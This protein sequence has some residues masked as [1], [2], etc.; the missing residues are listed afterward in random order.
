MRYP[1]N[2]NYWK[3]GEWQAVNERLHDMEKAGVR[4]NPDRSNLFRSLTATGGVE[5]TRVVIVGQDPYPGHTM[6]TG[7]AFSIPRV[8]DRDRFPPTLRQFFAEYSRDLGYGTPSH[9]DLSEWAE[10]GVLLW[11]AIPSCTD[12]RSLSHDWP[13]YE[14]LNREIFGLLSQK[15]IVFAFLG[16]VAKRYA[17]IPGPNNRV[18]LTSHPSPRGSM[19]SRTPFRGSRLFSTINGHL[20]SLGLDPIDW[21]LDD[22]PASQKNLSQ[23]ALAGGSILQNVT[24]VDLGGR[25]RVYKPNLMHSTFEL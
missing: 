24:G 6:A 2:L 17:D 23:S 21:R 16:S 25:Q 13:E 3:S 8:F 4:Y 9:G 18:I 7:L 10:Q 11:N 19:N 14:C 1:W 15:G 20:N 22:V 5:N 12:G